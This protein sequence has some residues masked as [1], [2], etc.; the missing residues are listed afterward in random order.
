MIRYRFKFVGIG[1][2]PLPDYVERD[3]PVVPGTVELYG[4][5]RYLVERVDE[6]AKPPV[7]VL[8]KVYTPVP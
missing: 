1:P 2:L 7:V 4:A 5:Q 3:Q 6:Q 8:R